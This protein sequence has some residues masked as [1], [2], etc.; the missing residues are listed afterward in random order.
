MARPRTHEPQ[1][2]DAGAI[3]ASH[4][5]GASAVAGAAVFRVG[6]EVDAERSAECGRCEAASP[7]DPAIGPPVTHVRIQAGIAGDRPIALKTR[8]GVDEGEVVD[9]H[10]TA[11]EQARQAQAQGYEHRKRPRG[12][13]SSLRQ[14]AR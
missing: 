3:E 13:S 8:V 12:H 6:S 4:P 2:V 14:S 10:A 9:D 1:D 11:R 5:P 7:V